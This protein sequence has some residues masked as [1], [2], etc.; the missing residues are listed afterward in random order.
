MFT[1]LKYRELEL[2]F[3]HYGTRYETIGLAY[4]LMPFR[5]I[6]IINDDDYKKSA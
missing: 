6:I 3:L 2:I 4:A 5:M 1:N